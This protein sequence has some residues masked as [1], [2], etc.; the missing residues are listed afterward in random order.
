[1]RLS[2]L[3]V[4]LTEFEDKNWFPARLRMF[5]TDYIRAT[6]EFWRP[7]HCVFPVVSSWLQRYQQKELV[8]LCSGSGGPLLAF[9]N[10]QSNPEFIALLTDKFPPPE[11]Q[12]PPSAT[13]HPTSVDAM[14]PRDIPPCARTLFT[15]L[16][17]FDAP[18]VLRLLRTACKDRVPIAA[19]EVTSLHPMSLLM[20]AITPV[21]VLLLTPL[22][23]WENRE[24]CWS[25]LLLTYVVP[26]VPFFVT[27][28][29]IIS[30]LNSHS[31]ASLKR[32]TKRLPEYDWQIERRFGK[33][34]LPI[35]CLTGGPR[36]L[37]Q[38]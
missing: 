36:A 4:R 29:G 18:E 35:L 1:M 21:L 37:T 27:V 19:F 22:L 34:G 28:D 8:D 16:H 15:A 7:Y 11:P 24:Y 5:M 38:I 23:V 17:H 3:K 25:R 13:Y 12:L 2:Q 31:V 10:W 32:I 14:R 33:L 26:L 9:L 30:C 20:I 6:I